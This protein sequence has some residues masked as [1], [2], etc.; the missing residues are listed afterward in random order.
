MTAVSLLFCSVVYAQNP[1]IDSLS[2]SLVHHSQV[3]I[4]G[5]GFGV[6]NPAAPLR[7][8]D[9]EDGT[10]NV[11]VGDSGCSPGGQ[12]LHSMGT[13][14]VYAELSGPVARGKSRK[15]AYHDFSASVYNRSL[16]VCNVASQKLYSS[17]W[18]YFHD[19]SGRPSRNF[20][21]MNS[22]AAL[23]PY[24]NPIV[25]QVRVDTYPSTNSGHIYSSG[26]SSPPPAPTPAAPWDCA[27][28]N[29]YENEYF[30][31]L[32]SEQWERLERYIDDANGSADGVMRL[33]RNGELLEDIN[34]RV[35]PPP[36]L[37]CYSHHGMI[38]FNDYFALD[39]LNSC[40]TPGA[41]CAGVNHDTRRC[42]TAGSPYLNHYLECLNGTW[43]DLGTTA[44]SNPPAA[45]VYTDDIYVDNTLARVEI[46]PGP[47]WN[48]RGRCEIQLPVEWASEQITVQL[49]QGALPSGSDSYLFV[50]ADSGAVSN[51]MVVR[52]VESGDTVP[53]A[54][55]ASLRTSG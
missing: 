4:Q 39:Y 55:P 34:G 41:S 51:A 12:G 22:N 15:A 19:K 8:F 10:L 14:P 7:W 31:P 17:T 44:P 13:P 6:K 45:D 43:V 23:V 18:T 46:C 26:C 47:Q 54:A 38:K 28:N 29:S 2:G 1:R 27:D 49:N 52:F 16:G 25:P 40:P 3:L 35:V 33:W 36:S 24:G 21:R 30:G 53:P 50:I 32:L 11:R 9:L 20:K 5:E 42:T 48:G 37:C